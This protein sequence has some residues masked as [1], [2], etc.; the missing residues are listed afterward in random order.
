MFH[1]VN[2]SI[3][4]LHLPL[5]LYID[6][7]TPNI[8]CN[9]DQLIPTN[10]DK[11]TAMVKLEGATASDN[12]R[13]VHVSCNPQLGTYFNIGQTTVT[14]EA[15]DGSGNRAECSFKFNVIGTLFLYCLFQ[16]KS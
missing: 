9:E 14:C 15:V 12:S 6:D 13:E 7:Q 4:Y 16:P 8:L 2:G 3:F 11:P 1:F 10:K 5:Y